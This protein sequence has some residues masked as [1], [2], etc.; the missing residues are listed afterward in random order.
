MEMNVS[1]A[2]TALRKS[3][4]QTRT[5]LDP[6][7]TSNALATHLVG[8]CQ[9]LRAKV[10]GIYLSFGSEPDTKAFIALAASAGITL[11]APRITATNQMEFARFDGS[12]RQGLHGFAEPTGEVVALDSLDLVIAPA[13]AVTK[14][15]IRL[16]RGA[17]YY[18]RYLEKSKAKV[19]AV[20][21]ANEILDEVPSQAHD[22]SV[23]YIVTQD[24][25]LQCAS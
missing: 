23:D 5:K 13:L 10:V 17:G 1:E 15:G 20:V 25:I 21:Y 22:Q 11:A 8:L 2:K 19:A 16:G 24:G 4:L 18:D 3:I 9:L 7:E 12:S 6:T 14:S